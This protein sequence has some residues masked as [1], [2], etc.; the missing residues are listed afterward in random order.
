[1]SLEDL[2]PPETMTQDEQRLSLSMAIYER[3][4]AWAVGVSDR[5]TPRERVHGAVHSVLH[6][7][8]NGGNEVPAF[9]L[10]PAMGED[11]WNTT[12]QVDRGHGLI[13]ADWDHGVV[14]KLKDG[15]ETPSVTNYYQGIYDSHRER[16]TIAAREL[17]SS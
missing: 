10:A 13:E 11:Q 4:E 5:L 17:F 3:A 1:M 2:P 15:E 16:Y 6:L 7:L 9:H 14:M 8:E 12:T